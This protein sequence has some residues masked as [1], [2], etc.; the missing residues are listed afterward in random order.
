VMRATASR[1]AGR[2]DSW[3]ATPQQAPRRRDGGF[4]PESGLSAGFPS[5]IAPMLAVPATEL[6]EP[7]P[8]WAAEFKWDGVRAVAYLS[9]GRLRLLSRSGRDMTRAYPELADLAHQ[10]GARE[11]ILDGEIAAFAAGRPSFAAL[12][13]R[14]HVAAPSARLLAAVPATYLAFDI[15]DLGGE[16]LISEPYARRRDILE[17]QQ[18]TSEQVHVPPSFRG[19]GE[20]VLAVSIRDGLEGVVVKRLDSPYRPGRRSPDWLKIKNRRFLDVVVGGISPG[21]G[22]RAGQIGSLLVGI[23]GPGGLAYAGR[24]GTGFTQPELRRLEQL[25]APLRRDRPPFAGPVPPAQD[26]TWVEPR[27]VIEVSY[28]ELTPDGILRAASYQGVA[29]LSN[30]RGAGTLTAGTLT[31]GT[32]SAETLTLSGPVARTRPCRLPQGRARRYRPPRRRAHRCRPPQ[33]RGHR[34]PPVR[35]QAHRY[36][37]AR[38]RARCRPAEA[39]PGSW[40]RWPCQPPP[41]LLAPG[42]ARHGG[43]RHGLPG[44][45]QTKFRVPGILSTIPV[46]TRS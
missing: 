5:R 43:K 2:V 9:A 11:M 31:A 33:Y 22:H 3:S 38:S 30:G 40:N 26:V 34:C 45:D 18:L 25:F 17:A 12:Q 13:R 21:R 4:M 14:M 15:M 24:V 42:P 29:A 7:E 32:S 6:P 8:A 36:R 1:A 39:R 16:S 41:R 10:A 23:P 46:T 44:S 35:D 19:G 28:A 20:A 27:V 37:R